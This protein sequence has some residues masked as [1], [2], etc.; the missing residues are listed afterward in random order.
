MATHSGISRS[1]V[2]RI[3]QRYIADGYTVRFNAVVDET[4]ADLVVERSDEQRVVE[5]IA[6]GHHITSATRDRL[7]RWRQQA[8]NRFIDVHVLSEANLAFPVADGATLRSKLRAAEASIE[9]LPEG[10]FLTV[11][12]VFEATARALLVAEHVDPPL[13]TAVVRTLI[14]QGLVDQDQARVLLPAI[15]TR[16]ALAHGNFQPVDVAVLR[17]L[18]AITDQLIDE[19]TA[20]ATNA[21]ASA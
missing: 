12:A 11:W 9:Q 5:L 6:P 3:A 4:K 13:S 1:A 15:N 7:E 16:N 2:E 18:I 21:R 10:S 19:L 17:A 20:H 8:P 14:S